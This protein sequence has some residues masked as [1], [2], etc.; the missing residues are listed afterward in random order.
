MR[1]HGSLAKVWADKHTDAFEKLK[2]VLSNTPALS[3]PDL[4]LPFCVGTDTSAFCIGGIYNVVDDQIKYMAIASRV[5]YQNL[6]ETIALL[7]EN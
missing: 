7:E 2:C 4:S 6:K 3:T 5:F 1:N